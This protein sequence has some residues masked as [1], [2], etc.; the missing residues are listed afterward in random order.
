M[1]NVKDNTEEESP[2]LLEKERFFVA[3]L[4]FQSSISFFPHENQFFL[5]I[6]TSSVL[7]SIAEKFK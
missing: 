1:S 2:I 5:F 3:I 7:H 6:M 4:F